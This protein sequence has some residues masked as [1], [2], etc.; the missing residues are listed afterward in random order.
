[1]VTTIVPSQVT[2]TTFFAQKGTEA[3]EGSV[4]EPKSQKGRKKLTEAEFTLRSRSLQSPP[5]LT[6]PV[7]LRFD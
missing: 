7:A 4:A 5:A 6:T 2:I 3:C 1:M